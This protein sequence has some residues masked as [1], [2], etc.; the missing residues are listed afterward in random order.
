MHNKCLGF[1]ELEHN[2]DIVYLY[3]VHD[4]YSISLG[5]IVITE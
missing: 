1:N 3:Y 2:N 4:L 5:Y